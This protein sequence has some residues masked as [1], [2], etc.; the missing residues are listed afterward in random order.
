MNHRW[1]WATPDIHT[2][3]RGAVGFVTLNRPKA[4]N[5]LSLAMVRSLYEVLTAW[6]TDPAIA[7]VALRGSHKDG[8]FGAFCAG[9]DIR[10]FHE[11]A[12]LGNPQIDDFFTEEYALNALTHRYAK[13]LIAFMDGVVMGGGMGISQGARHR[14]VT[15]RS[16]LAM[17]ETLI[18]LFP[19]VGGGYFLGRCPGHSGEWLAL[20]GETVQ[21]ADALAVGWADHFLPSQAQDRIWQALGE[22]PFADGAAVSAWLLRQLPGAPG[23]PVASSAMQESLQQAQ[24]FF[25]EPSVPAIVHKLEAATDNPWAQRTAGA[26]RKRS[27]L[28]LHVVLE[29]VR[30]ART[31]G[32]GEELMRER[33]MVRHCFWPQHLGRTTM[34]SEVVEG[35]RAL[36]IDKD[37]Q[38]RW[39]P[40]RIE[41]VTHDM[42]QGFFVSPWPAGFHP[43]ETMGAGLPGF[44]CAHC[45]RSVR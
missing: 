28:M 37:Q 4:L 13:P 15:E 30:R 33:V 19:D 45:Q 11:Q 25:A 36:V 34:Q 1:H 31:L 38:P 17:P 5:A 2:E 35:I 21:G 26:L 39:N 24:A 40:A 9:G 22:Q 7:A 32:I 23:A 43:L 20:T 8:A 27:P 14:I 44:A 29:Q 41:D 18:G 10:F 42:V 6:Q 12:R 3:V 16:K